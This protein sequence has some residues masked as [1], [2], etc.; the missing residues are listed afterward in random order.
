MFGATAGPPDGTVAAAADRAA[1]EGVRDTQMLSGIAQSIQWETGNRVTG[2]DYY[3]LQ[4]VNTYTAV[5][6]GTGTAWYVP[7]GTTIEVGANGVYTIVR[8]SSVITLGADGKLRVRAY[9]YDRPN[10]VGRT[11]K[12]VQTAGDLAYMVTP[13]GPWA[14]AYWAD[15]GLNIR[16]FYMTNGVEAVTHQIWQGKWVDNLSVTGLAGK[17]GLPGP[18]GSDGADGIGADFAAVAQGNLVTVDAAKQAADTGIS[19][20]DVVVDSD[21]ATVAKT[22]AYTDLSAQPTILSTADVQTLVGAMFDNNTETGLTATY[23]PATQKIDLIVSTGT[24]IYSVPLFSNV[25]IT[26]LAERQESDFTIS[27]ALTM[28]WELSNHANMVGTMTLAQ[29]TLLDGASVATT[30]SQATGIAPAASGSTTFTATSTVLDDVGDMVSFVIVGTDK[31]GASISGSF[32]VERVAK[33]STDTLWWGRLSTSGA[34]GTIASLTSTT[35]PGG[36][37]KVVNS[38]SDVAGTYTFPKGQPNG[39]I[40]WFIPTSVGTF[41]NAFQNNFNISN[42][43]ILVGTR[44]IGGVEYAVY[45]HALEQKG[46]SDIDVEFR[47]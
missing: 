13:T 6:W 41:K 30:T 10:T 28:T 34:F 29:V 20:T 26:G 46:D 3:S 27:G 37:S 8:D 44:T 1:A 4:S 22:G 18:A 42:T 14:L 31:R 11:I 12:H 38:N 2:S 47:V 25:A 40:G 32:T 5:P 33:A 17:Q 36:G 19:A 45:R 7:T 35:L 43:L 24:P 16:L 39:W 21:L 9:T 23:N 15:T